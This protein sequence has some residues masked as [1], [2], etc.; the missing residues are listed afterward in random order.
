VKTIA[1]T[2]ATTT[3]KQTNKQIRWGAREGNTGC[4]VLTSTYM[5]THMPTHLHTHAHTLG[6]HMLHHTENTATQTNKKE[7]GRDERKRKE[8]A[9]DQLPT[10]HPILDPFSAPY[11]LSIQVKR[12]IRSCTVVL[13]LLHAP[14]STMCW[15]FSFQL[16]ALLRGGENFSDWSD[17][18][19]RTLVHYW[20]PAL[21]FPV[22]HPYEESSC[23]SPWCSLSISLED[24][25]DS[26]NETWT[27]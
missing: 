4:Q 25:N 18:T 15:R 22:P 21:V 14:Q 17:A 23:F 19:R 24:Q 6:T 2:A 8:R 12:S 1:A 20:I 3:S 13:C 16:M 27:K 5:C 26:T 10:P 11:L 7:G 9:I